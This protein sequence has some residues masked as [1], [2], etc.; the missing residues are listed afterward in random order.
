MVPFDQNMMQYN[1][2][3]KLGIILVH[4]LKIYKKDTDIY[5]LRCPT[6]VETFHNK[7]QF[8][9]LELKFNVSA[10]VNCKRLGSFDISEKSTWAVFRTYMT[11][12][13]VQRE[14]YRHLSSNYTSL[15]DVR[16]SCNKTTKPSGFQTNV[17][18]VAS[19]AQAGTGSN[20][21]ATSAVDPRCCLW[22]GLR[23]LDHGKCL[24]KEKAG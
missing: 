18:L 23:S 10:N 21:C 3:Q 15:Y 6:T 11:S 22:L 5:K 17:S 12:C 9:P 20:S 19:A 2:H 7:V 1:R 14:P 4:S 13:L 24:F 8:R 16:T